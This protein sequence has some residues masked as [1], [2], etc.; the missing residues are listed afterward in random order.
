VK[1]VAADFPELTAQERLAISRRLLVE[2]LR[3]GTE[4]R[5]RPLRSPA[6]D[7]R[8]DAPDGLRSRIPAMQW[9]PLARRLAAHWWQRHPLHAAGQM[10]RPLVER[11][12]HERPVAL[13]S[14][15][16][17]VGALLVLTKPWRLLT[18]SAA[19]AVLLKTSELAGV[20]NTLMYRSSPPRKEE[21]HE[22]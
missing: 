14:A 13:V 1:N 6:S 12:A 18:V 8:V 20:V 4:Q 21:H 17:G 15:A 5:K 16:A 11:A 9:L 3:G 22:D 7:A 19:V 2:Q 10:A